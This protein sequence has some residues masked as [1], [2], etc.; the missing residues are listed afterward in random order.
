MPALDLRV[1]KSLHN[2]HDALEQR[3]ELL[4]PERLQAGY[5]AFRSRFGPDALKSLD[6]L[7]LLNAMHAH[8]NKESLVYWLEF[9][10]DE[11]FPGPSFGSIAGGSAHKFGLFRRKET[12]QWVTGSP[13]HD[14]NI[15]E[16][17][18][19][20]I[21]RKHRDQ[22]LLGVALLE[23][24]RAE[25]DDDAYLALQTELE[26]HAPDI[27]GLAWSHKYWSLLFPEKLDDFHNERFQ[28]YNLLRL[29]EIPPAHAGLYVC[30]GRFVQLAANM[31]W[32]MNHLTTVLN[33]RHGPPLRYWRVGTRV[34][35]GEGDFIW[36]AMREGPYVAIGW[37]ELGDLS[38]VATGDQVK[39]A[40][41]HLLEEKYPGDPRYLGRKAGEIRD[42]IAR[43]ED[44]DV[45][46][47]ADGQQVLGVGRADGPYRYEDTEPTEA[48]HRRLVKWISTDEWKLPNS[49]EG[50]QTTFFP[51][52]KYPENI[53]EIE[54][55]LLEED[56]APALKP[57]AAIASR[58]QRLSGIPGRIQAILER[59]GQAIIFGPPGTG[60]TY[61]ARL[62][63]RD[64]AAIG[65]FGRLFAELASGEREIVEG[66]G[67]T[68]GLVRWCTFHPAYG[69]EDFVEGFRPQQNAAKQLV[70]E[71]RPGIF[72]KLCDD[73]RDTPSQRFFLVVDEI[74]RGDIPRIFG[75][76]LTLL[77]KDKRGW[78]ITLPL[79]GDRF[80]VPSNVHLLGTMNTADRSIALLDT[81]L[82][83]R[84]GFVE[85]M[86]DISI[87]GTA[88]AGGSIPLGPW[89]AALNDRL[90]EHL[91][92]DARNLQIGHAYLMDG[93]RPVADFAHFVRVLAEDVVPLLEEYCYEDY[94][95]LAR[96]LGSGL[97][98]EARQRIREELFAQNKWPELVQALL[99]PAPE[100]VTASAA[101]TVPEET[102]ETSD[103]EEP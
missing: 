95:A 2:I 90:R 37:R 44:G 21:A 28:R 18:A 15:S 71:R 82:R 98:D 22:L 16:A 39:E 87:L 66:A 54:R 23:A 101:I 93:G 61:W 89:L 55:Q 72:K 100:I 76:L 19:I 58:V 1:E 36:P 79:S 75:E 96:I 29:L 59:K 73:A 103:T 3:G 9:K 65:A 86:P 27:C 24:L 45:V 38:S 64:L 48:P 80:T 47:A 99:E 10:N 92:R 68:G 26:K 74:N 77:E 53:V 14:R 52:G 57:G 17:D 8:G 60:K 4:S 63:A 50:L 40:V 30:A 42:F 85:L 25:A 11:E 6:G 69:Y 83:R 97:V 51:L 46:V 56:T 91:G 7:A 12:G 67:Q 78:E 5:A 43:M 35:G 81:A 41:R 84:F 31:N 62:T 33:T 88:S 13:T 32:P 102:E 70:F 94:G 20:T 49:S 34:G